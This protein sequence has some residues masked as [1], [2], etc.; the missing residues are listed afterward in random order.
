M[1]I[2]AEN[3]PNT[4]DC[5]LEVGVEG[6]KTKLTFGYEAHSKSTYILKS[7]VPIHII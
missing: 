2:A 7:G 1:F 4:K 6:W 3:L 5:V